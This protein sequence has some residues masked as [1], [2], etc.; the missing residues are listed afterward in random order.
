MGISRGGARF[1]LE[2]ARHLPFSGTVLQLGR[3]HLFIT[4]AELD[5]L[6]ALH[7]AKL[8]RDI[9][10]EN[11]FKPLLD[12]SYL[13]DGS[14][15]SELGFST[16]ESMDYSDFE[17]ATYVHDLNKPIPEALSGRFDMIYDGGTIEHVFDIRS[18]LRNIFE[19]LKIGGRIIHSSPSSNHVDHGFYMFSPTLFYDYYMANNFIIHECQI[20][21]YSVD[22]NNKPWLI[23]DYEPGSLEGLAFGG[24]NTGHLVGIYISAEKTA[25]STC[26]VIPQQ[27]MYVKKWGDGQHGGGIRLR[28]PRKPQVVN[29]TR[30]KLVPKI[31]RRKKRLKIPNKV[32]E[33]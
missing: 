23:F 21:L 20:F 5:L 29:E 12:P 13:D 7:A 2:E 31:F 28:R 8:K 22:H 25:E 11:I 15:F 19:M 4:Q 16:V 1:L 26:D 30:N 27:G 24:F 17:Q 10:P 33:Y 9:S 32:A 6:A 3:Q 14:F 18:S